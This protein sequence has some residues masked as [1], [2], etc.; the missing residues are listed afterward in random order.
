MW[1]SDRGTAFVDQHAI[2]LRALGLALVVASLATSLVLLTRHTHLGGPGDQLIYYAQAG[3]LLPFEDHYYGPGYFLALRVVHDLFGVEWFTAGRLLSWLSACV[4]LA[5]CDLLFRRLVNTPWNW[6]ALGL[7]AANPTFIT[8]SYSSLTFAFG[9]MWVVA[10]VVVTIYTHGR[11]SYVWL[12]SGLVFGVAFLCRF[13]ALGFFLG[14]LI[15]M[16][17]KLDRPAAERSRIMTLSLGGF[18]AVVAPWYLFLMWYQGFIPANHNFVHLTIALGKFKSFSEVEGLISEYGSM[19]GVLRADGAIPAIATM[20]IK[21]G[22]KFP[23]MMGFSL[24]FLA[25]GWL[26]PGLVAT[27]TTRVALAPW[28]FAFLCGLLLTGLGARGWLGYYGAVLPFAALLI[29]NGAHAVA[30]SD[31]SRLAMTQTVLL[32]GSTLLWS[33]FVVRQSFLEMDWPEWSTARAY[34]QTRAGPA[35]LISSSA[36]SFPYGTTLRFVRRDEL[37]RP[38]QEAE[39]LPRLRA[40]GVTYLVLSER[41]GYDE[42]PSLQYLLGDRLPALPEGFVREV[43]ITTPRRLAIYRISDPAPSTGIPSGRTGS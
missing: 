11:S 9:S 8:Y 1:K 28:F 43:L 41:H 23:F 33:P 38:G 39:L 26:I 18:V 15:G 4:F 21:E 14:A 10:A 29:A 30:R 22:L 35:D 7:V 16:A 12:V 20:V 19:L 13:Q 36:A 34:L 17:L 37:I 2:I 25:A 31:V 40:R 24:F 42:F 3:N 5:L 32:L 27:A 6:L